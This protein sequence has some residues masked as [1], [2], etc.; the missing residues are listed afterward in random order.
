MPERL[1]LIKLFG[2]FGSLISRFSIIYSPLPRWERS[3]VR[4][5]R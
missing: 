2:N 3:K 1:A 4:V 5:I